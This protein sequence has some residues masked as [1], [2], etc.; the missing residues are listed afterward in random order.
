VG[1]GV[2]SYVGTSVGDGVGAYVG[3]SVGDGAAASE[4]LLHMMLWHS[5]QPYGAT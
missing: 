2:G 4:F 3:T 5:D 1:A